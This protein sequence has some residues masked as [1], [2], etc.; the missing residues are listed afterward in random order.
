MT[1]GRIMVLCRFI[2]HR[3][4][5]FLSDHHRHLYPFSKDVLLNDVRVAMFG[6]N[7]HLLILCGEA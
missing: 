7:G 6:N 2:H 5:Y 1:G 3:L 4:G